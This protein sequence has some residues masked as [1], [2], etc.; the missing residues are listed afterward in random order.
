MITLIECLLAWDYNELR[1]CRGRSAWIAESG[2][3]IVIVFGSGDGRALGIAGF[4]P[5]R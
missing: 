4:M 5:Y 1:G 2:R 3:H